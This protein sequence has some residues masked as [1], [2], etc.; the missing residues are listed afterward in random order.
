MTI[1]LVQETPGR[2]FAA[3][4]FE[5]LKLYYQGQVRQIHVMVEFARRGLEAMAD[6]LRLAMDYF[7]L[8]EEHFPS[9]LAAGS[10]PR[11]RAGDH[12]RIV[13]SH[14]RKSEESHPAAHRRG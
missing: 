1:R 11:D 9:P 5:P 14:R 7:S 6:A 10:G 2:G 13:A 3:A 4:D 8:K 12:T